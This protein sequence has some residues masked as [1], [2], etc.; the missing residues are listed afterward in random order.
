MPYVPRRAVAMAALVLVTGF[1]GQLLL[2]ADQAGHDGV[3]PRWFASLPYLLVDDDTALG[4]GSAHWLISLEALALVLLQTA[5]L[6]TILA[7]LGQRDPASR[8]K[9]LAWRLVLPV[10]GILGVLA[11][12]APAVSSAD[13]FGYVGLGLLGDHPFARPAHFFTG[14]YA[15]FFAYYPLRPTIYGPLWIGLNA[16][17]VSLG[18]TFAGKLFALRVFGVVQLSA[19]AALVWALSR[20]R[21]LAAAVALNPMLW[22]QFV[23]D[24]HND[25]QAVTLLAAGVVLVARRRPLWAIAPVAAAGLVKLPFLLLGAVAFGRL[26]RMPA[27]A[28]TTAAVAICMVA[29]AA[30]GG[31]AY[32]ESLL[33]TASQRGS[34]MD[35]ILRASKAIMAFTPVAVT[36]FVLLRGRYPAFAGWLYPALAPVLFPWYLV[37]A[38]PYALAAR[39]GA[40]LTL[41]ALPL[42]GV[43]VDTIYDLHAVAMA[44]FALGGAALVAAVARQ[45]P[46]ALEP[47]SG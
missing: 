12:W 3:R 4:F 15:R 1:A 11:L 32:V 25:L 38:L 23:V 5:G 6:A 26:G 30:F 34:G 47:A 13:I 8:A 33:L 41:L 7:A 37:W 20:S 16:A 21:A 17:V 40:L 9:E 24:A 14:E 29:S 39:A 31:H 45:S 28:C 44:L 18:S 35:P 46:E 43:L 42:A 22:L 19:L 10:A 2:L 36:A 27:L